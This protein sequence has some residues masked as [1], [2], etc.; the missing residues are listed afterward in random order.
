VDVN[1]GPTLVMDGLTNHP[2]FFSIEKINQAE[3][4]L[5]KKL[6]LQEGILTVNDYLEAIHLPTVRWGW[7]YGWAFDPQ[8][9]KDQDQFR[10]Y[11]Y[12][13]LIGDKE[14]P[15]FLFRPELDPVDLNSRKKQ[16]LL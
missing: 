1:E 13:D 12:S 14:T 2:Y 3:I 4:D 7:D 9:K 16:T 10:L 15:C 5:R 8:S 11:H 6:L